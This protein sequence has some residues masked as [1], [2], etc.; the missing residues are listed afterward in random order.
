[1]TEREALE[2]IAQMQPE[3]V[4]MLR[5]HGFVFDS[6]GTEPGNWQHLA[7]TLYT[8]ICEIDTIARTGLLD[9]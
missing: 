8:T 2:R 6:I 7:F 1:M 5:R 4:D 9:D 3:T